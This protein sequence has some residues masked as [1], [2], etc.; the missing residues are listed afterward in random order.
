MHSF[1]EAICFHI[2]QGSM[3]GRFIAVE[4]DALV[5]VEEFIDICKH[6]AVE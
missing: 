3:S 6:A 4:P 1:E 5:P 2:R